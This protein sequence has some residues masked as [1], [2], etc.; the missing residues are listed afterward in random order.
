VIALICGQISKSTRDGCRDD[1]WKGHN[2]ILTTLWLDYT[3]VA[4]I[5]YRIV[6]LEERVGN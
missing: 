5:N 2:M 4:V 1:G 6:T 3:Y